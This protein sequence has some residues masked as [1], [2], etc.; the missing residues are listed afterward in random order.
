MAFTKKKKS[1]MMREKLLFY[2]I[3]GV[4]CLRRRENTIMRRAIKVR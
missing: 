4:I 2:K 3:E 1:Q